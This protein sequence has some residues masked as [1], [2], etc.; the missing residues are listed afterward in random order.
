MIKNQRNALNFIQCY[1]SLFINLIN[2]IN[3]NIHIHYLKLN[4]N[5]YKHYNGF[6]HYKP[7]HY[8][9]LKKALTKEIQMPINNFYGM[10]FTY[11][12]FTFYEN[13]VSKLKINIIVIDNY[14][15]KNIPIKF[16]DKNEEE[17]IINLDNE[18]SMNI[19]SFKLSHNMS[20]IFWLS[21]INTL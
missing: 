4:I 1:N 18:I 14:F 6:I 11:D 15:G 5:N 12:F 9:S 19:Y 20:S 8:S 7:L 17:D 3:P 10:L 21:D 16:S 2:N 13:D